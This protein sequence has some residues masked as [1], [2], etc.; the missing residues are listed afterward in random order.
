MSEGD[1]KAALKAKDFAPLRLHLS[2]GTT[3]DVTHPDAAMVGRTNTA[4]MIDGLIN[5]I[6]NVHITRIEPLNAVSR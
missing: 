1:L 4:V 3:I 2:S 6:A 5:L